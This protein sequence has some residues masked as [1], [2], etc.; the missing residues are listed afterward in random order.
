VDAACPRRALSG[1][2][3]KKGNNRQLGVKGREGGTVLMSKEEL[4]IAGR[5][6]GERKGPAACWI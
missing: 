4:F 5:D 3:E 2:G 1:M 6:G